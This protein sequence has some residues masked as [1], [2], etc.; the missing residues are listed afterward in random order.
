MPQDNVLVALKHMTAVVQILKEQN[1]I[2]GSEILN[3]QM[4]GWIKHV[5]SMWLSLVS[6]TETLN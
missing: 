5:K 2:Y 3:T 1:E 6:Q 4:V